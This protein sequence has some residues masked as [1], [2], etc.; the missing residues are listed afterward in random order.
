MNEVRRVSIIHSIFMV[1]YYVETTPHGENLHLY[2]LM[3]YVWI[4]QDKLCIFFIVLVP[5]RKG[6][7][8]LG[9]GVPGRYVK[10]VF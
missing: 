3:H 6:E 2:L 4:I 9:P 1:Y 5:K 7:S 10:L 8:W